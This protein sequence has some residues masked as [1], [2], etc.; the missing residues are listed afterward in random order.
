MRT[1]ELKFDGKKVEAVLVAG[2]PGFKIYSATGVD[3]WLLKVGRQT[4]LVADKTPESSIV[5][6]YINL[7]Y[8]PISEQ[9]AVKE[10]FD[11]FVLSQGQMVP[12][13]P[14]AKPIEP[15]A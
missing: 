8:Q 7:R 4:I 3:G 13:S 15:T 5:G 2:G 11:K 12:L 10:E 6:K 14:E 1:K 9:K